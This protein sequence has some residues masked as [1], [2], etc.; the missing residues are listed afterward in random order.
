[1]VPQS[2][3]FAQRYCVFVGNKI[4][5]NSQQESNAIPTTIPTTIPT[6]IQRNSNDNSNRHPMQFQHNAGLCPRGPW[7]PG[8]PAPSS[9]K[10][11]DVLVGPWP[12]GSPVQHHHHH[13]HYHHRM[14]ACWSALCLRI[15]PM[16]VRV[17]GN[18]VIRGECPHGP[19]WPWTPP[20]ST[21]GT[22]LPRVETL[23]SP[24]SRWV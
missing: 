19:A 13:I 1:M 16:L 23:C 17:A 10:G 20:I 21:L 15:K 12:P 22:P 3:G 4:P 24:A 11:K 7:S 5:T 8:Y 2:G 18:G 9:S 6:E 14:S